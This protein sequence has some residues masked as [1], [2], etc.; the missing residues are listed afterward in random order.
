VES[1]P[2]NRTDNSLLPAIITDRLTRRAYPTG[3]AGV[4]HSLAL[5]NSRNDFVLRDHVITVSD[6]MDE[7]G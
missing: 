6:E 1:P 5:P 7:Q 3:N 4:R 2:V